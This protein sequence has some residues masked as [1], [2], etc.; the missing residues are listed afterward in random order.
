MGLVHYRPQGK[1][2]FSEAS[3]ILFTREGDQGEFTREGDQGEMVC[4]WW[5]CIQGEK[6]LHAGGLGR[7]PVVTSRGGH[8]SGLYA[9]YWN[10]FLCVLLNRSLQSLLP[11]AN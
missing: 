2:M 8:C 9:S 6:G 5:V 1:V 3:L 4:I 10:A 7:P 11:P